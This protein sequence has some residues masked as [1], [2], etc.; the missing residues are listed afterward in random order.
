MVYWNKIGFADS[1]KLSGSLIAFD[2]WVWREKNLMNRISIRDLLY[3]RNEE[4][5]F[6]KV[7]TGGEKWIIYNNVERK[8]FLGKAEWVIFTYSKIWFSSEESHALCLMRG[9]RNPVLWA[10]TKQP[11]DK[12][13][14]VLLTVR[15]IKDCNWTKSRISELGRALCFIRTMRGLVFLTSRQK[16]LEFG[17]CYLPDIA[18]PQI[19]TYLHHYKIFLMAKTLTL[20]WT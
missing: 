8:R 12:F 7:V 14:K 5:F 3:K 15:R 11:D 6:K 13:G 20:W 9:K 2:V 16:L 4:T 1:V 18:D 19:F 17:V 10:S